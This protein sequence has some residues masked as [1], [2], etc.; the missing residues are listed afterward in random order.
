MRKK[1]DSHGN[2][3]FIISKPENGVIK[4]YAWR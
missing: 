1:K 3:L 4:G 2:Q